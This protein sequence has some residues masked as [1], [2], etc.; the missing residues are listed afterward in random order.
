MLRAS[1][2]HEVGYRPGWVEPRAIQ[3]R[4]K[5]RGRLTEPRTYA[6]NWLL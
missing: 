5:P 1:A 2:A 3:R 6:R 4:P